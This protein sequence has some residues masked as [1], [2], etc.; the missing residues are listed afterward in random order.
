MFYNRDMKKFFIV[1]AALTFLPAVF[2]PQSNYRGQR[3]LENSDEGKVLSA[4]AK[5]L[6]DTVQ[7]DVFFSTPVN[8]ATFN[9]K[10][11]FI[12]GKALAA[13]VKAVFN[14]EGNQVRILVKESLPIELKIEGLK[15]A[16]GKA[17]LAEKIILKK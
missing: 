6:G 1:L 13:S 12:N 8:P 11:V 3:V 9:G 2:F 7:I 14:R 5:S 17:V 4:Q 15:T 16:A 10:S